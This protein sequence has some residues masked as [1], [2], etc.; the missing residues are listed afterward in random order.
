MINLAYEFKLKP[1]KDQTESV[2]NTFNVCRSVW[3][4]ALRER[5]DWVNSRKC[6]VNACSLNSEYIIDAGEPF[7]GYHVQAKRLTEAKKHDPFLRSTNAQVL[8]QT[9]RRLDRAWEDI[10]KR[11][12]GFP[13][14]KRMSEKKES[15]RNDTLSIT[16]NLTA[17]ESYESIVSK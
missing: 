4:Y 17:F 14:F 8:Q 9:L 16:N 13:R 3:N 5:K 11:G 7:P 12:F 6:A 15:S 1:N 2:E 10:H